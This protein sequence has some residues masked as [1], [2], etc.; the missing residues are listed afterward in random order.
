MH[1]EKLM[2][3]NAVTVKSADEIRNSAN[4]RFVIDIKG[5]TQRPRMDTIQIGGPEHIIRMIRDELSDITE[6]GT[7][8]DPYF[9]KLISENRESCQT[10]I[11]TTCSEPN[12]SNPFDCTITPVGGGSYIATYNLFI[13][14]K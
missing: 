13:I 12:H 8:I 1:Y 14:P 4:T 11:N 10:F 9:T 7:Q 3:I 6:R 2:E 5:I